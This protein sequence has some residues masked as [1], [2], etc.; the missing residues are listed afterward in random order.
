[1]K[2]YTGKFLRIDLTH[3]NVKEEKLNPKLAKNYIGARGLAVK[4][5][6]D[7]VAADIDPLSPENK[8]F[9]ATGPLTGTMAN[10]GGRLDVVTKGPLTGGITGSNTGGYWGAELKYAGYDMLVFEGK[11][12][13]PVYVWIDNGEVEI[14][15]ASHLWGK[16]TYETDTKL[17]VAII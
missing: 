6:Y 11:A 17:R 2:G 16:N 4:Y 1:M 12:D 3:G 13:K 14:R 10:A 15:D 8:L 5:F 9:L 7:E